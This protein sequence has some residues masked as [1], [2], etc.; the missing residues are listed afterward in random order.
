MGTMELAEGSLKMFEGQTVLINKQ[1]EL[2]EGSKETHF[3]LV[4]VSLSVV[5]ERLNC[6][7]LVFVF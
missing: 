7:L 2:S 1:G 5:R 3:L 4:S 6:L